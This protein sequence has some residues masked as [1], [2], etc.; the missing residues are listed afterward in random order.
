[1][2]TNCSL[3]GGT[4]SSDVKNSF[5]V[6]TATPKRVKVLGVIASRHVWR[7]TPAALLEWGGVRNHKA[8]IREFLYGSSDATCCP[9]FRATSRWTA[10][11]GHVVRAGTRLRTSDLLVRATS[12]GRAKLGQTVA[13][14]RATYPST[15]A[16]VDTSSACAAYRVGSVKDPATGK[17]KH[18]TAYVRHGKVVELHT[19]AG[20]AATDRGAG[21]YLALDDLFNDY[22]GLVTMSDKYPGAGAALV[23]LGS[24]WLLFRLE[25][26]AGTTITS[27]GPA[28]FR[29]R[30]DG[31]HAC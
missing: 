20:S 22:P 29:Y 17:R 9:S 30:P 18:I 21:A 5:V 3:G 7:G 16:K 25:D 27:H 10:K 19:G 13:Q 2:L 15:F 28:V 6:F 14:L 12:I 26:V 24:S 1:V 8:K 4:A 31:A 11:D 23:H